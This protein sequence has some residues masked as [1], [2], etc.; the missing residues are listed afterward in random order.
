MIDHE[1]LGFIENYSKAL[2]LLDAYD[3][4]TMQRPA[5]NQAVYVL[6]Y[7]ECRQVIDSMRFGNE[8]ELFGAE[9]DDSFKGK[10]RQHLSVLRRRR[11]LSEPA[12]KSRQSAVLCHQEPQLLGR[13]QAYRRHHVSVFSGPERDSVRRRRPQ[14]DR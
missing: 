3:H 1:V 8:S 2:D 11:D 14:A 6:G 4:Q 9:K 7:E 10:H 5:G 13:Q 12:G